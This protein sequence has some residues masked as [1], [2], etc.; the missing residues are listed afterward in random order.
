VHARVSN[1]ATCVERF[2]RGRAAKLVMPLCAAPNVPALHGCCPLL[3]A[4]GRLNCE[5]YPAREQWLQVEPRRRPVPGHAACRGAA[6]L[7]RDDALD[8][9]DAQVAEAEQRISQ[10]GIQ[11]REAGNVAGAQRG[12]LVAL[13]QPEMTVELILEAMR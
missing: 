9:G 10:D 12:V 8:L 13:S 1:S 2:Q 6:Q 4:A 11:P 7:L 5:P 3:Q